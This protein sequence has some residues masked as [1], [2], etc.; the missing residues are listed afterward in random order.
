MAGAAMLIQGRISGCQL[1]S[2]ESE[3]VYLVLVV[4]EK[5]ERWRM[6]LKKSIVVDIVDISRY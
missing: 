4:V 3:W 5:Q 6:F 2:N 1:S